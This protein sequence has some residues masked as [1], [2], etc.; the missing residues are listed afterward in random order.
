MRA[1]GI[2]SP[3]SKNNNTIEKIK[4]QVKLPPLFILI[5]LSNFICIE[6]LANN[7]A[8]LIKGI[9]YTSVQKKTIINLFNMAPE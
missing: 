8:F 1:P 5:T 3:V 7:M 4:Y 2:T 9:K 6:V